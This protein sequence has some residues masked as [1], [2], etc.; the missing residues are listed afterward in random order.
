[1]RSQGTGASLDFTGGR[2][3]LQGPSGEREHCGFFYLIFENDDCL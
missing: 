3:R 1:M 2:S